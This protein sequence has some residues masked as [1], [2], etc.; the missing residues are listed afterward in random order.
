MGYIYLGILLILASIV[1]AL[2]LAYLWREIIWASFP[3][4][5]AGLV[6]VFYA[7]EEGITES[8]H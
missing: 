7:I 8:E 6:L 5:L 1:N 3:I 2:L 4:F